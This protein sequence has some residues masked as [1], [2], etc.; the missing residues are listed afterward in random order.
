MYLKL[1]LLIRREKK[2]SVTWLQEKKKSGYYSQSLDHKT[3]TSL[4]FSKY[5]KCLNFI[6]PSYGKYEAGTFLENKIL[7]KAM[8]INL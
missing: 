5:H 2:P 3:A 1:L 8:I 4:L 7:L 6:F